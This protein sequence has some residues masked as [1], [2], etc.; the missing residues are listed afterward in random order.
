MVAISVSDVVG[1]RLN[2]TFVNTTTPL[3]TTLETMLQRNI[4]GVPI[5]D[6]HQNKF[7]AFV[8]LL[9]FAIHIGNEYLENAII[10]GNVWRL[11]EGEKRIKICDISNESKRNPFNVTD[12]NASLVETL[13]LLVKDKLHRIA[14]S[15]NGNVVSILTLTDILRYFYNNPSLFGEI[16]NLTIDQLHLGFKEVITINRTA[17]AFEAFLLIREKGISGVAVL[18]ENENLLGNISSSDLK[19]INYDSE[20]MIRLAQ[21]IDTYLR[22]SNSKEIP[23]PIVVTPQSTLHDLLTKMNLNKVHRIYLTNEHNKLMGV[24]SQID[25]VEILLNNLR[26][27]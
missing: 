24:I 7:I 10:E 27:K 13:E 4:H 8:D 5:F 19:H 21:P 25:I 20:I 17:K 1:S 12:M 14:I 6:Q 22:S 16:A 23:A 2:I 9:D 18:D 3:K 26:K 11:L 15:K